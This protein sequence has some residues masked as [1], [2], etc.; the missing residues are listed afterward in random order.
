MNLRGL[1]SKITLRIALTVI[2]CCAEV[3]GVRNTHCPVDQYSRAS[4]EIYSE[5]ER[6][7]FGVSFFV[8]VKGRR[9]PERMIPPLS[10]LPARSSERYIRS[11]RESGKMFHASDE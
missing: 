1:E 8:I 10:M 7:S 6:S 5:E 4:S 11:H 2:F 9:R 3:E